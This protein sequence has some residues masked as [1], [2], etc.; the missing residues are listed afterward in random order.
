MAS[1]TTQS[2]VSI[3]LDAVPARSVALN[4][5]SVVT[6]EGRGLGTDYMGNP[7][8]DSIGDFRSANAGNQLLVEVL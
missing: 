3:V 4:V 2:A 8:I 6:F 7:L 1:A 5:G